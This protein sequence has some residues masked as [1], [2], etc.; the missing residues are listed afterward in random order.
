MPKDRQVEGTEEH[1][2]VLREALQQGEKGFRDF[3]IILQ[4]RHKIFGENDTLNE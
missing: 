3:G 1:H 4:E 2:V